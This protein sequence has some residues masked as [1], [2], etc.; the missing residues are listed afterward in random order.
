V[1]RFAGTA[2]A[3]TLVASCAA[4][5]A[6]YDDGRIRRENMGQA[7]AA[8]R[9]NSFRELAGLAPVVVSPKLHL[10]AGR[11]AAY[12]VENVAR[13]RASPEVS[14]HHEQPWWP[15]YVATLPSQRMDVAGFYHGWRGEIVARGR[16]AVPAV[17]AWLGTVYHRTAAMSPNTRKVGHATAVYGETR[18]SVMNLYADPEDAGDAFSLFPVPQQTEVPRSFNGRETPKPPTPS[19]GWPSS[20]PLSIIYSRASDVQPVVL[21]TT[22]TVNGDP[23]AHTVLEPSNDDHLTAAVFLYGDDPFPEQARVEVTVELAFQSGAID[24]PG[25]LSWGFDVGNDMETSDPP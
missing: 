21:A 20:Y 3:V 6:G 19:N 9:L 7:Q 14:S 2:L 10:A 25:T 17:E 13:Y 12:L 16:D 8:A 22:L 23:V 1:R 5:V 11:H 18:A 24:L 4:D 15:G